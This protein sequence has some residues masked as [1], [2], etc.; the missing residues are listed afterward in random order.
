MDRNQLLNNIQR[1]LQRM[2]QLELRKQVND[3]Q[4]LKP[5]NP[6]FGYSEAAATAG[7]NR[8]GCRPYGWIPERTA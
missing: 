1:G 8:K 7:I 6:L 4:V 3:P 5:L 2:E